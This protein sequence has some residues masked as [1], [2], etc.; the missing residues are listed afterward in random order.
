MQLQEGWVQ[1]YA[2]EDQ[3]SLY[4]MNCF[5]H[6]MKIDM[7]LNLESRKEWRFLKTSIL[8]ALYMN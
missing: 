2:A 5:Y 4:P 8:F 1:S 3:I 6:Q 7:N